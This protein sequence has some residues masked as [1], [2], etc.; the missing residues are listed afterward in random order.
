MAAKSRRTVP[1]RPPS[2]EGALVRRGM[3]LAQVVA[4][5]GGALGTLLALCEGITLAAAEQE[6][7][8]GMVCDNRAYRDEE[9]EPGGL[10]LLGVKESPLGYFPE[11]PAAAT[12]EHFFQQLREVWSDNCPRTMVQL[13][14]QP[15]PG[16]LRNWTAASLWMRYFNHSGTVLVV[17]AVDDYLSH[18]EG[19]LGEEPWASLLSDGRVKS[20]TVRAA[21]APESRVKARDRPVSFDSPNEGKVLAADDVMRRC[22]DG[23]GSL[24]GAEDPLHPCSRIL[25]RMLQRDPLEYVAP[26]M[27]FDEVWKRDLGSKHIDFL[28]V[29]LGAAKMTDMFQKGFDKVLTSRSVSVL[30]F[31]VDNLWTPADLKKVVEWLD[32]LDYFSMFRLVCRDSS[33]AASFS[34]HGPGGT[35]AGPTTYLPL[36]GMDIDKVVDWKRMPLPQDVI[37][38][39]LRQ[40]DVF[41]TVQLGDVHCDAD[42]DLAE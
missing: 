7:L 40:P 42:E 35:Q 14:L 13:G 4:A 5:C 33:Q 1:G 27:S 10:K 29:D 15:A 20:K 36:S 22:S 39:D 41:K 26:V 32:N 30:S 9:L 17:D 25:K 23:E 3:R 18:F 34:Y 16:L 28:H 2:V 12:H 6:E 8:R 21:L 31:R 24:P 37:V 11:G 19:T 38:L